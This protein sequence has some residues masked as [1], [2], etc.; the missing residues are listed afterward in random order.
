MPWM[1][2]KQSRFTKNKE[3]IKKAGDQNIFT[4]IKKI[5]LVFNMILRMKIF[6]T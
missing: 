6:K 5:K 2:L 4:E 1:H 3:R